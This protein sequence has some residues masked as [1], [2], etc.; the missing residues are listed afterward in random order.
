MNE[1]IVK[2]DPIASTY[3]AL[4]VYRGSGA[5]EIQLVI[6]D[7]SGKRVGAY[8]CNYTQGEIVAHSIQQIIKSPTKRPK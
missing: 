4:E 6:V 8:I 3:N 5:N 2:V 1:R 7:P